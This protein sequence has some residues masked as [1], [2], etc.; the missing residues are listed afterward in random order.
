MGA[1]EGVLQIVLPLQLALDN[2]GPAVDQ[3]AAVDSMLLLRDP[4]RLTQPASVITQPTD[5]RTRVV[6]FVSNLNLAPA[7]P[8]N[9]VTVTLVDAQGHSFEIAAENVR[10]VVGV[11]MSQVTFRLPDNLAPGTCTVKVSTQGRVSNTG[12]I[13]I[14]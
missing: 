3:L 12:T 13:R 2:S 1:F 5:G 9:L 7:D 10:S 6:I 11:E 4:F 14:V 8:P